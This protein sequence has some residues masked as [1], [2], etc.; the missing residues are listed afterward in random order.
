MMKTQRLLKLFLLMTVLIICRVILLKHL[1]QLQHLMVKQ[2]FL[3]F[4][5]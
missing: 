1:N 4:I 2:V 3:I 5:E